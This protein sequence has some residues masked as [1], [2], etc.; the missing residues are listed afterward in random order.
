MSEIKQE[1]QQFY[2]QV[3]WQLVGEDVY[4]NARYEDLRPVSQNYIHRCHLRVARHLQANGRFLLD[5]GSGPVQY[6]EYVEYGRGYQFHVCADISITALREAR[7]R[8][9]ERGLYV[10]ADVAN[11]PFKPGAFDGVVS[12]HTIHHLP[13]GEHLQ[14]Y[15]E[16]YRVLS[17]HAQAVVVNGWPESRLMN[18]FEPFIKGA[19]R[20]RHLIYRLRKQSPY[21]SPRTGRTDSFPMPDSLTPHSSPEGEN[22]LENPKGTFTSRHDVAWIK[23]EVGAHMDDKEHRRVEILVWRSVSVRF[24]RA[25]I[26]PHLG[27]RAW[28]GLLYWLEERYPHFFGE[29]GKYPLI[30]ILKE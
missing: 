3:G 17:P 9:G 4:Q 30:V 2:D 11:L 26:H 18:V 7:K 8:L 5:A 14:A 28:L 20:L 22:P 21:S 19:N 24:L 16:I 10:A 25:L 27:G 23:K 1:V 13:E 6:P 15:D 29:N 12:L